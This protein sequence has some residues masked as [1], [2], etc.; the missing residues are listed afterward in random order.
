MTVG[1]G[2]LNAE[3][4]SCTAEIVLGDDDER[5][6]MLQ[7]CLAVGDAGLE[8][9]QLLFKGTSLKPDSQVLFTVIA[10]T[11]MIDPWTTDS[12]L[13][14]AKEILRTQFEALVDETSFI[15]ETILKDYLRPL[16]SKSRPPTVTASGRKAEYPEDADR[17]H[18]LLQDNGETKP[19]KYVD[20]R[21]LP[22][23]A[24]AVHR[25]SVR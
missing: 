1:E 4:V 10:F 21:A 2:C 19:W 14:K 23:F 12:T 8:I 11:D 24:W 6:K 9:L 20:L 18:G 5:N 16:F 25:S 17:L 15:G 22:V 13:S 3:F 7:N